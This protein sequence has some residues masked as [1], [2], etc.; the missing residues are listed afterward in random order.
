MRDIVPAIERS[1]AESVVFDTATAR[2]DLRSGV[3][4]NSLDTMM[5]HASETQPDQFDRI[6]RLCL[7]ILPALHSN[8]S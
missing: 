7:A 5:Q 3:A 4:A 8:H 6:L 2:A 1:K